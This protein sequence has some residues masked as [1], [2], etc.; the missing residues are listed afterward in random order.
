[1]WIGNAGTP[2]EKA[3]FIPPDS[4]IVREHLEKFEKFIK[5]EYKDTLVQLA[6]MHAQFEIIHPFE[7]DNGRVG[8]LLIPLFLKWKKILHS[9]SFYLSEYLEE[10]RSEYYDKLLAV[11]AKNDW[12]GW[13]KYML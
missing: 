3:R 5:A 8:R 9:P 13:I 11:S 2:I 10:N 7:D 12:N 1:M 4:V 6:I